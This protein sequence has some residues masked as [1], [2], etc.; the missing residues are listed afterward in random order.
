MNRLIPCADDFAVNEPG[1]FHQGLSGSGRLHA[2]ASAQQNR[3][4]H[5]GFQ[6]GQ[7][8]A[9]SVLSI[10]GSQEIPDENLKRSEDNH[11]TV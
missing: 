9:W 10:Q 2:V 11:V 7:A 1:V 8:R 4:A 6:L 5:H 3:R